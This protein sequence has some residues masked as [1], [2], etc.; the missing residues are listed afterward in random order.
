MRGTLSGLVLG[1]LMTSCSSTPSL[2][3]PTE[4]EFLGAVLECVEA[5]TDEDFGEVTEDETLALARERRR[6]L[7]DYR[8]PTP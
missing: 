7:S 5:Q 1:M 2:D 3:L 8:C 6:P 4:V